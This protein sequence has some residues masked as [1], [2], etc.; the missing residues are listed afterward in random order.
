MSKHGK[1]V[2][3]Q[4]PTHLVVA[5]RQPAPT[6][7]ELTREE[8]L[9]PVA[10]LV[11]GM[12]KKENKENPHGDAFVQGDMVLYPQR[13]K[14]GDL[15]HSFNVIF[16]RNTLEWANFE[17]VM[18]G[19]KIREEWRSEEPRN[20]SNEDLPFEFTHD[21]KKMKRYR[22]VTLYCLLPDQ[23]E[24]FLKDSLSDAPTGAGSVTPVAIKSRN[25]SRKFAQQILDRVG[26]AE[27][28]ARNRLRAAKGMAEVPVYAYEH[29]VQ[30]T[31]FTNKA[32]NTF[33][34]LVYKNSIGV[35][36]PEVYKLAA[37][38]YSVI[39]KETHL[40]TVIVEDEQPATGS[41]AEVSD[42]V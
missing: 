37:E 31:D 28:T 22:Q 35:Q 26:G 14:I 36:N 16:L 23:A 30:V 33:P 42:E 9:Y 41:R 18:M 38:A 15:K 32:G 4:E 34:I 7:V 17:E 1:E 40:Q 11:H 8:K 12:S 25:F 13:T 10:R 29:V 3:V 5:P 6:T 19:G 39:S 21:G 20:S 2:A 24:A 27:F